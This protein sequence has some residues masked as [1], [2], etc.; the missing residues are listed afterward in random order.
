M[1]GGTRVRAQATRFPP[2]PPTQE[3][4]FE[5]LFFVHVL[6]HQPLHLHLL[7]PQMC[8]WHDEIS[9]NC[10][11]NMW[12]Y[13]G[14]MF[15]NARRLYY[16]DICTCLNQAAVWCAG[17]GGTHSLYLKGNYTIFPHEGAFTGLLNH[18]YGW[19]HFTCVI[20]QLVSGIRCV[21]MNEWIYYKPNVKTTWRGV[22]LDYFDRI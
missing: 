6:L 20:E 18:F 11:I 1:P 17:G 7:H 8:P 13:S 3:E 5:F 21:W 9:Q 19:W 22:Y 2:P 15:K 12:Y 16:M 4:L 10:I 14:G